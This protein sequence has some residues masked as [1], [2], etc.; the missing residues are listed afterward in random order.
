VKQSLG[1]GGARGEE[2]ISGWVCR[3]AGGVI[4]GSIETG[5]VRVLVF[6]VGCAQWNIPISV[7]W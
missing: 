3:G 6:S 1:N 2:R 5:S 4:G 7:R